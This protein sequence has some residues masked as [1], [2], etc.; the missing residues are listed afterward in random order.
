MFDPAS[1][2]FRGPLAPHV[3]GFWAEL[4]RQGYAPLSGQ[5]LLQVA[6]HVSRW[7]DDRG[8][9]PGDLTGER[10]A[11]FAKHRRRQGYSGYLT[12]QA[13]EPL[14]RYLRG[15]GIA[16]PSKPPL[17]DTPVDRFVREYADYLAAERGL[18]ASTIRGYTDF[19]RGF[20]DGEL[21]GVPAWRALDA[22]GV[23]GFVSR[24]FRRSSVGACK[25]TVT[26][27]R[28]LLRYLHL[29]GQVARDLAACVPAVAGWRLSSLPKALEPDQ[30]ERM[31][32]ACDSRSLVGVRDRAVLCLLARLGMRAGEVAA[33]RLAD[34]DWRAG[35]L[36][37]RGKPRRESRLPLPPDVGKSIVAYLRRRPRMASRA[38]FLSAHAPLRPLTAHA[39]SMLTRKALQAIGVRA[40]SAHVLRHT[41]AT[42]M[43]HRGAS[44]AEIGH[45]LRHRHIDTTAIY[46]KVDHTNLRALVQPWPGDAA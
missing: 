43:L 41:A 29:R 21:G 24:E 39:I 2:R 12:P 13:V 14:L 25:M 6:A 42:Q 18:V 45:V 34:I 44:L 35:E 4:M 7:L 28:S 17:P 33:L 32:A 22:G 10:V 40:G 20:I 46:A 26:Q 36:V 31:L 11:Q 37:V 3:D 38:V 8:L 23:I 16:P 30:V 1:V 5:G 9:A 15:R 19:A 27:L